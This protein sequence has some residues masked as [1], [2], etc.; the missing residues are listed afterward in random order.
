M[1]TLIYISRATSPMAP[2]DLEAIL[3][4][5]RPNNS[6]K[7]ISGML[8]YKNGEFMQALEGKQE[9]IEKVFTIIS[10]D[11]RHDEILVL[12]RKEIPERCFADWSM[13]FKNLSSNLADGHVDPDSFFS[14]K[15]DFNQ[16]FTA[17]NFL[18]S[19]YQN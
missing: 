7:N 12:S 15:N 2:Q 5:S 13:G 11:K 3:K 8:I 17:L 19:F 6:Q 9:D 4:I 10:K 1:F 14:D 16:G 18:S